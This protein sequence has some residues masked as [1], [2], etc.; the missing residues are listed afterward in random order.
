MLSN[1]GVALNLQDFVRLL[2]TRWVVICVTIT[3]VVLGAV[4]YTLLTTPQYQASTR[5]FVSATGAASPG[6]VY[7]GNLFSQERVIS[8][9]KLITGETLAQRTIDK[10]HL[11]MSVETLRKK[12]KAEAAENTVLIDVSVRDPSPT[13]A[14][15]IANALSDEFVA[16]VTELETPEDGARP[17][18]R[19]VVEQHASLPIR[20]VVPRTALN[21]TTGI[22]LG[23]LLGI[24]LAVLRDWVDNTVK[25]RQTLEEITEAGLVAT[26]PFDKDRRKDAAIQFASD[27]SAIA[28]AF[29]ELR[30]N[31]QFLEVD[32]PPRVL[33][34][35]S[36][37]P[38]EGKTTTAIN[39][40]L[41]L[42]EADH[43]VVLVDGDMRRPK[44]D[45]YLDLIGSVGFST[46][47]TGRAALPEVL[48]KTRFHGLTVLTSGG[49]PPNP[50]ELL[51]TKA[52]QKVLSELR[53]GFDYVIVDSSPLLAVTDGAILAA[54][55]DGVL[56]IAR[57]AQTK[58]D[59]LA[60]GVGNLKNVGARILGAMFTMMPTRGNDYYYYGYYGS[61][62]SSSGNHRAEDSRFT[63]PATPS[64]G[65]NVSSPSSRRKS[66]PERP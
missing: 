28:E 62:V 3:V 17:D 36:S 5:L 47:L 44:V 30:T 23:V 42:A 21:V 43:N 26:I 63:S 11:A 31:L 64:G 54:A 41:A 65:E 22:A 16:M 4:A 49:I 9:T 13:Q 1:E 24:G 35:T 27:R 33:A 7:E 8:Y 61:G 19:I 18:A 32:N 25:N 38:G 34:V 53:A 2:R 14:R 29:R 15:D 59:Q 37:L 40:A 10:L 46:V 52:A 50:S 66:R 55:S 6:E 60:H 45:K 12:V 39:I 48:Q 51:G 58:R 57:F 56:L 20:P